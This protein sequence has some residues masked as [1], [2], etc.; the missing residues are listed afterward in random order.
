MQTAKRFSY[1]ASLI[2]ATALLAAQAPGK[3]A[4]ASI[5]QQPTAGLKTGEEPGKLIGPAVDCDGDGDR[6]DVRIDFDGDSQPDECVEDREAVPEPPFQQSYTPSAA[7]FYNRLPAVGWNTTYQCGDGLYEITLA[8]PAEDEVVYSAQGLTISEA[9]TY[10]DLDPNLNHPLIIQEPIDGIRYSFEKTQGDEFYEYAIADYG[11]N[12]GLYVYQT[13]E[14]IIA[15]PCE[16]AQGIELENS[17][18]TSQSTGASTK[19]PQ[20]KLQSSSR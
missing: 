18:G 19:A 8:R 13:G 9:V 16:A 20:A 3:S 1:A 11:G 5:K 15:T 12:V 4:P 2:V 7:D 14:Q 6:N 10:D 17:P